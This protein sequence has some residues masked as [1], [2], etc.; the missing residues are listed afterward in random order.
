MASDFSEATVAKALSTLGHYRVI[1]AQEA[2]AEGPPDGIS[3]A[4]LLALGLRESRLANI[5]NAAKTDKG[6]FQISVTYHERFLRS[7]PGC[8]E[9]SWQAVAGHNA[10]EPEYVPRYTPALNYAIAMLKSATSYAA[11]IG[12]PE[13]DRVRFAVAA[14][15]AGQGGAKR[16]WQEGDVDRYTTGKDYSAW[17]LRH[18]TIVH[19]WIEAHPNWK[20]D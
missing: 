7:E 15:N 1:A 13:K 14:Y 20:A 8:P 17:V 4:L 11:G 19:R 9:G 5:S 16:G 10:A 12:V 6:C 3:G 2:A 18:R